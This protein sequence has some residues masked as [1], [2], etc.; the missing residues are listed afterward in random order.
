MYTVKEIAEREGVRPHT[1]SYWIRNGLNFEWVMEGNTPV[2]K[3][4]IDELDRFL[5]GWNRR[6]RG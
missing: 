2:R 3:V 5:D 4:K 1:V 6:K